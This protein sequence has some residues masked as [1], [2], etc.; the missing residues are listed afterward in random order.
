M[1][2]FGIRYDYGNAFQNSNYQVP[3]FIIEFPL[4][5]GYGILMH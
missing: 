1:M 4:K 5:R 3:L 2:G